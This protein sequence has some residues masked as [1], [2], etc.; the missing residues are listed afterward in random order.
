MFWGVPVLSLCT[1]PLTVCLEFSDAYYFVL[2]FCGTPP[3]SV[4]E[5]ST[6]YENIL[7]YQKLLLRGGGHGSSQ[8][9]VQLVGCETNTSVITLKFEK[10]LKHQLLGFYYISYYCCV[11]T[12]SETLC[13]APL[14]PPFPFL[15][16]T[17]L[18]PLS[19]SKSL[20]P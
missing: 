14:L 8:G 4:H 7:V 18:S 17:S 13:Q 6:S 5:F 3:L 12:T 16:A 20:H 10:F 1:E 11:S 2:I 15:S 9:T 19:S